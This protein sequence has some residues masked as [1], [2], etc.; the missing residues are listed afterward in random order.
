MMATKL[1]AVREQV[2]LAEAHNLV[3][4]GD[5]GILICEK[6]DKEAANLL[7]DNDITVYEIPYDE[8]EAK[9]GEIGI[10]K[11]AKKR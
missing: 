9:L 7:I 2:D 11:G 1:L 6:I 8:V 5:Y 10:N 4:N 3:N